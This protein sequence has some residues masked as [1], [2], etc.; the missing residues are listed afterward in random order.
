M[1]DRDRVMDQKNNNGYFSWQL[2]NTELLNG[3]D[4]S[5]NN[6]TKEK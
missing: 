4:F 6:K 3:P 5:N 2:L 1:L